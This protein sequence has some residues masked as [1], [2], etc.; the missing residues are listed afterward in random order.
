MVDLRNGKLK[1][2]RLKVD[3]KNLLKVDQMLNMTIKLQ[4]LAKRSLI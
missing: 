3:L 2:E 1:A 4:I